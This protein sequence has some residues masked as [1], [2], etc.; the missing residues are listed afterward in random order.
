MLRIIPAICCLLILSACG[1]TI[2]PRLGAY[3]GLLPD[4]HQLKDSPNPITSEK[5]K[6]KSLVIVISNNLNNHITAWESYYEKGGQE[7]FNTKSRVFSSVLSLVKPGSTNII[8]AAHERTSQYAQKHLDPRFVLDRISIT[9]RPYFKSIGGAASIDEAKLLKADYIAILDYYLTGNSMGDEQLTYGGL[10]LM[11]S[12]LN[13]VFQ[14]EGYTNTVLPDTTN[15]I[16]DTLSDNVIGSSMNNNDLRMD[17]MKN[18]M[19]S[20]IN[21]IIAGIRTKLGPAPVEATVQTQPAIPEPK[22][23]KSAVQRIQELKELKDKGLISEAEFQ[24]KRKKILETL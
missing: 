10:Y 1:N 16:K 14:S 24:A 3:D 7:R 18:N 21:Q 9:L 15:I 6:N 5:L 13:R 12:T 8:S 2:T 4:G 23:T 11:E 17:A 19:D 22:P 20:T